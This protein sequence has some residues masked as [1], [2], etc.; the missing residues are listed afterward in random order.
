MRGQHVEAFARAR[1]RTPCGKHFEEC[2]CRTVPSPA[3]VQVQEAM[4][5]LIR[6]ILGVVQESD[7]GTRRQGLVAVT[8]TKC[9]RLSTMSMTDTPS[10]SLH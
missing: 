1:M 3:L 4:R 9:V 8:S 10:G 7:I 5:I 2:R 6:E